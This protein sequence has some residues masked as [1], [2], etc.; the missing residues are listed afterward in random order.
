MASSYRTAHNGNV[1][2]PNL[3]DFAPDEQPFTQIQ[4]TNSFEKLAIA[5]ASGSGKLFYNS[6]VKVAEDTKRARHFS[7]H[8]DLW[9]HR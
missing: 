4:L 9:F 3:W 7:S 5:V 2:H 1:F 6:D 8:N